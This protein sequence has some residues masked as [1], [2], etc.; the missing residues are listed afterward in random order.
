M[1]KF[2]KTLV[3]SG[4]MSAAMAATAFAAAGWTQQDNTWVYLDN[5]GDK[6]TNT[7]KMSGNDWFYLDD[8]GYLATDRL[9]DKDNKHFYVDEFGKMVR[10]CWIAIKSEDEEPFDATHRWYYFGADGAAYHQTGS[11]VQKKTINGK[12]YA[13]D[14]DGK[15]LFGYVDESGTILDGDEPV[16]NATYYFHGNDDGSMFTGWMKYDEAL[17]SYD[18]KEVTWFYFNT[19]TGKKVFNTTKTINGKKYSFD[20]NGVMNYEWNGS[21]ATA[22]QYFSNANDGSLQKKSWV[23]AI[24]S[25]EINSKDHDE[26]TSR[27]FYVDASGKIVT[28]TTKKI[29]G[30]WYVFNDEGIMK[31]GLVELSANIPSNAKPQKFYDMDNTSIDDVYAA[32]GKNLYYFSGDATKDGSMKTGTV[33]I[34]L[35]DDIYTFGFNKQGL[36]YN[37]INNSKLYR[38]GVLQ[39][40]GEKKY[41][42]AKF[43]N[44]TED[45]YFVVNSTGSIV[46]AGSTGKDE[47]DEYFAVAKGFDSKKGCSSADI[48]TYIKKFSGDDASKA[49]SWFAKNA[50]MDGFDTANKYSW[51]MSSVTVN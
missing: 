17:N 21:T 34:E 10:N 13:F 12:E 22:S 30:H 14:T 38:C 50:T 5:S 19:S 33:K 51:S 37:G 24:P 43:N 40:A 44:G 42:V 26:E 8:D 47:N 9:V 20:S 45:M 11:T 46:K 25:A 2:V 31:S 35:T 18:N 6:V 27:W 7:W 48:D 3:I 23:Y 49:A 29:N 1:N 4:V 41:K 32:E 16:I 36:A 15:M 28:N 39:S